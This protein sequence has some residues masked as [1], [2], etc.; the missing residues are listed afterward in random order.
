LNLRPP[1]TRTSSPTTSCGRS[2]PSNPSTWTGRP[3]RS[4]ATCRRS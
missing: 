4:C 3:F 2:H 1:A